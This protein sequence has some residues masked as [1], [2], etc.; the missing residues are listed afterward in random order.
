MSDDEIS[1]SDVITRRAAFAAGLKHF[2]TGLEC[3]NGH[4]APRLVVTGNCVE[5]RS[6]AARRWYAQPKNRARRIEYDAFRR[7]S[8]R[9]TN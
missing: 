9:S 5:C 8:R 2:Y 3:R 6:E 4:R 1:D 7:F